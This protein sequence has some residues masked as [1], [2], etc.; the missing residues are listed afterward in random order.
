MIFTIN[1]NNKFFRQTGKIND[2]VANDMLPTETERARHT[3]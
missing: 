2:I 1:F 3:P